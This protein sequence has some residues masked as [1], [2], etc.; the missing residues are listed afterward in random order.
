MTD[1]SK[2]QAALLDTLR[3]AVKISAK[4]K[5]SYHSE[6]F[7]YF[8]FGQYHWVE[9]NG[10][11]ISAQIETLD[12]VYEDLKKLVTPGYLLDVKRRPKEGAEPETEDIHIE[13]T[14]SIYGK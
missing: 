12:T 6:W 11:D 8:P 5:I 10:K 13:Y 9:V 4:D 2:D 3:I 14:L 1:L 7:G